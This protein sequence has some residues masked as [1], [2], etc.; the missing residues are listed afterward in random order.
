MILEARTDIGRIREKN[1]DVADCLEHPKDKSIKLLIVA[2]GMGGKEHGEIAANFVVSSLVTWF[3]NKEV[4]DL[5]KVEETEKR[6]KSYIKS[7]NTKIIHRYGKNTIGTTLTMALVLKKETLIMNVGDSRAYLYRQKELIQIT[8]DD[9]DVWYYYK[10]QKVKKDDLRYFSNNNVINACIGI[11][12]EL[13]TPRGYRVPNNYEMLLL[14]SDGVTDMITD[15]KI[16]KIIETTEPENILKTMIHEAVHVNQKLKVPLYLKR[17]IKT[18]YV[19][20]F[21][22]RDNASGVIWI[23]K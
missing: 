6:L 21:K 7:L 5:N 17:K 23:K 18:R 15:K 20:P 10:F 12:P 11:D 8:E 13:C 4:S 16:L 19:V 14:F 22:G 2:D 1:E 9:A 3:Q